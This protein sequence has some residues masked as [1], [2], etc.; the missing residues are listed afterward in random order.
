[1]FYEFSAGFDEVIQHAD[2]LV[3][4]WLFVFQAAE[5][6]SSPR[7]GA[8]DN[9]AD[10]Q[11]VTPEFSHRTGA[12]VINISRQGALIECERVQP[13]TSQVWLRLERPVKTDWVKARVARFGRGREV[14]LQ[15]Y[16]GCSDDFLLATTLGIDLSLTILAKSGSTSTFD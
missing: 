8:I 16:I 4:G 1:V 7:C 14:A 15:F 10:V 5:R 9:H 12:R 6:R 11:F 3:E 13:N 2:S